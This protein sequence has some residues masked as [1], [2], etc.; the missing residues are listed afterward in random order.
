MMIQHF[1]TRIVI[2]NI[3]M[4]RWNIL[5]LTGFVVAML[6][7]L[8][9]TKCIFWTT[10]TFISGFFRAVYVAPPVSFQTII[11]VPSARRA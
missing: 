1:V 8:H 5:F 3:L 11:V 6:E 7:P 10:L 2:S 4:L 9:M